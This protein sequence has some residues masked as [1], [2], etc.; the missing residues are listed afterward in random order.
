MIDPI[1]QNYYLEVSSPGMDRILYR[2]K[3]FARFTGSP[4]EVSLYKADR[5]KKELFS[6][7]WRAL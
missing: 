6:A 3:D 1:T 5:R 2:E 4:V 7:R